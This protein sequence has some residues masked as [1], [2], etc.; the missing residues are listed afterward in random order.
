[1]TQKVISQATGQMLALGRGGLR[2]RAAGKIE[3]PVV[4]TIPYLARMT[5]LTEVVKNAEVEDSTWLKISYEGKVGYV[6]A[7]YLKKILTLSEAPDGQT[8]LYLLCAWDASGDEYGLEKTVLIVQNKSKIMF[9]KT[10]D[11]IQSTEW[12]GSTATYTSGWA[13]AGDLSYSLHIMPAPAFREDTAY[14]YVNA[15]LNSNCDAHNDC[16][17]DY[18]LIRLKGNRY[19]LQNGQKARIFRLLT[20][21]M[22]LTKAVDR[23]C[24]K[25]DY[26]ALKLIGELSETTVTHDWNEKDGFSL[27]SGSKKYRINTKED[28]LY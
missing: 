28:K 6:S 17:C 24:S 22:P 25:P 4:V 16:I 10:E 27:I 18:T 23:E 7:T 9:Q 2:L 3:S 14:S 11:G 13:D 12:Y 15:T 1:M 20:E 21:D 5:H 8:E 26:S 19:Y